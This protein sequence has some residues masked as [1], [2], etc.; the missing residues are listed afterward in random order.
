MPS[1]F[2]RLCFFR[3]RSSNW[4]RF[5]F[6]LFVWTSLPLLAPEMYMRGAWTKGCH[7]HTRGSKSA[8]RSG[9]KERW[10]NK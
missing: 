9:K 4:L 10:A 8:S 1:L 7:M 6:L 5:S 3:L 2:H